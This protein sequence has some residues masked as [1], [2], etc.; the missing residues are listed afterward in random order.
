MDLGRI[1]YG[2]KT[3]GGQLNLHQH[4]TRLLDFDIDI[5]FFLVVSF[6]VTPTSDLVIPQHRTSEVVGPHISHL[7]RFVI[8]KLHLCFLL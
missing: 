7:L 3:C 5:L 6:C 8:S 2:C 1:A 4:H